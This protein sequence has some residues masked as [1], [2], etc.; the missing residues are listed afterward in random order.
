MSKCKILLIVDLQREFADIDNN[1]KEYNKVIEYIKQYANLGHYD[2]IISTV[3]RNEENSNFRNKLNWYD[4]SNSDVNS[5][6]YVKYINS[7]MHT[8]FI[9]KGYGTK[10]DCIVRAINIYNSSTTEGA[11]VDIIGCDIDACVMAIC[12]QLW[13]SGIVNFKVLTE[14]C[15]T[16]AK[17]F[18]KEDIIKIM[19][20]NFGKCIVSE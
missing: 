5:L 2:K 4:C 18:S 17:D 8:V 1:S 7:S 12:F 16:S 14:Y 11:E 10:S 6:E 3:F 9:K 19:K 20:R 15:Y 13:D